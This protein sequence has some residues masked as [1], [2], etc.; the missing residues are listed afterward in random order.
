MLSSLFS[1]LHAFPPCLGASC[2][3]NSSRRWP[4]EPEPMSL[5]PGRP[6]EALLARQGPQTIGPISDR[7]PHRPQADSRLGEATRREPPTSWTPPGERPRPRTSQTYRRTLPRQQ[8][9][10]ASPRRTHRPPP[11]GLAATAHGW[12]RPASLPARRGRGVM[13]AVRSRGEFGHSSRADDILKSII[14]DWWSG[15]GASIQ[16]ISMPI[17][18]IL[19]QQ[20]KPLPFVNFPPVCKRKRLN[21][22]YH[23]SS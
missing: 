1:S 20:T 7:G 16:P 17:N 3:R 8:R 12:F 22:N 11:W 19:M 18:P 21:E 23:D 15:K 6:K 9:D 13:P 14:T 5:F 4:L 10:A 2:V